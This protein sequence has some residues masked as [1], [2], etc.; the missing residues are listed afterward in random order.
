MAST[1]PVDSNLNIAEEI[2]SFFLFMLNEDREIAPK[3][4]LPKILAAKT[5]PGLSPEI[6]SSSIISRFPEA[7]IPTGPLVGG[8][9][10]VMENFVKVLCEE[11]VDAIQNE[12]RVDIALDAGATVSAAGGNAGG[13]VTVVGSTVAPHTGVG[14]AR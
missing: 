4:S 10:N 2:A 13:P 5:R 8:A 9:T 14:V 3:L 12:M 1:I 6:L 11:I 7:G